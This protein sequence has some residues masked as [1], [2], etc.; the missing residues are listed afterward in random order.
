[1]TM[2]SLSPRVAI[3]LAFV[4]YCMAGRAI[5]QKRQQLEQGFFNP[6]NE[7]PFATVITEIQI[8]REPRRS[9]FHSLSRMETAQDNKDDYQPYTVAVERGMQRTPSSKGLDFMGVR[10]ITREVAI[11]EENAEAWLYARVAFLFFLTILVTW[12]CLLSP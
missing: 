3:S 1:M 5:Y 6:L 9:S 2:S 4:I 8:T 11:S 7:N 10:N 12:V